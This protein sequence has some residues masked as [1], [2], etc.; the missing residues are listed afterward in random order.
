[1]PS[2]F[3]STTGACSTAGKSSRRCWQWRARSGVAVD[4]EVLGVR[5]LET[6]HYYQSL[7]KP[8]G[9]KCTAL[10]PVCWRGQPLSVLVLGRAQLGYHARELEQLQGLAPTLQLCEVSRQAR[11]N[12][13][14]RPEQR[15][16]GCAV[17]ALTAAERQVLSYLHLGYTNAEIACAPRSSPAAE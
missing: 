3:A 4:R 10:L 12:P 6:K 15:A 9:G 8:S 5:R 13:A 14:P 17:P 1:M 16:R 7:M 2:G 11:L